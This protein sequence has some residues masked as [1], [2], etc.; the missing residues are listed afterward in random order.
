MCISVKFGP[1][2][3]VVLSHFVISINQWS[4]LVKLGQT[5]DARC[6]ML[7]LFKSNV[8]KCLCHV[9]ENCFNALVRP[10]EEY[11]SSVCDPHK[12]TQIDKLETIF[13]FFLI[14]S[15]LLIEIVEPVTCPFKVAS[16]SRLTGSKLKSEVHFFC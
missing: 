13:N 15:Y 14:K 4:G 7:S 12:Q 8:H 1:V 2:D 16:P 9:K 6:Y 5:T 3:I 11:A 10:L